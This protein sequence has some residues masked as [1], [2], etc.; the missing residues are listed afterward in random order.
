MARRDAR[1]LE[2]LHRARD[3]FVESAGASGGGGCASERHRQGD[4]D[5]EE[6]NKRG[7]D[8]ID[9]NATALA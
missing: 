3:P 8:A 7:V 5:R 9:G 1:D 4:H 2:G 6:E